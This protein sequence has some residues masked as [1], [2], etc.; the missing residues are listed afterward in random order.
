M[1][2]MSVL[3]KSAASR[4]PW[5][6]GLIRLMV[7]AGFLSEGPQKYL[8]PGDP[9]H[10]AARFAKL[11]FPVPE[12]TSCFVSCFEVTCGA[13]VLLGLLTRLAVNPTLAIMVVAIIT[14]KVPILL[15]RGFWDMAH[16]ARTDFSMLLGSLFVLCVGAGRWSADARLFRSP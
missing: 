5:A 13:F 11:G 9:D 8:F 2:V 4:A 7:R 3:Q 6:V 16:A 14:T 10:G 12:F 15:T 1:F